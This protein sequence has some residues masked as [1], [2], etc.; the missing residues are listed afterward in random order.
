M[1]TENEKKELSFNEWL[2]LN[3]E[4]PITMMIFKSKDAN[5][6][7]NYDILQLLTKYNHDKLR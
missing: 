7:T 1:P 2:L 6:E 4:K 5:D 3:Y